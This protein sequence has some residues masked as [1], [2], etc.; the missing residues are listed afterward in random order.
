[1]HQEGLIVPAKAREGLRAWRSLSKLAGADVTHGAAGVIA[2]ALGVTEEQE[3]EQEQEEQEEQEQEEE[4]EGEE[5]EEKKGEAEGEGREG[6]RE[7]VH[8]QGLAHLQSLGKA[9]QQSYMFNKEDGDV[10][11]MYLTTYA[12]REGL[13]VEASNAAFEALF[14][15]AREL[16]ACQV[17]RQTASALLFAA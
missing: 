6:E 9:L 15:G 14:C 5:E 8:M 7:G 4:G 11:G 3:E 12:P 2:R 1:M 10:Q 16:M 13:V 17:H